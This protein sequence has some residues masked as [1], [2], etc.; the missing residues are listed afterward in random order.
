VEADAG[1][2]QAQV[3]SRPQ[4]LGRGRRLAAVLV[5]QAAARGRVVCPDAQQ[6]LCDKQQQFTNSRGIQHVAW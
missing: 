1:D 3:R 4:Q 2:L 6:Q 5:A